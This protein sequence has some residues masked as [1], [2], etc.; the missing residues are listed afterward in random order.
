MSNKASNRKPLI[1]GI[2]AAVVILAALLGVLLTQCTP[3]GGGASTP[4]TTA[5]KP[6]IENAD[7]YWNVDRALYDGMSEGGMSSRRPESDGYFHV[8]FFKDGE[9]VELKVE[10]RTI[11]NKLEVRDLMGL[12]FDDNGIVIDVIPIEDMPVQKIGW[13]FYVQSVA[14]I[15][16]RSTPVTSLTAWKCCWTP[17]TAPRSMI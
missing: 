4:E 8:R 10:N 6:V 12:V 16:S 1:V 17:R 7:L 5:A 9:F 15:S 2:I 11:V 13:K 14:A 3:G